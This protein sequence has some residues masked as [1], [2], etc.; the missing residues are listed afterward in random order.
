MRPRRLRARPT[1]WLGAV[2]ALGWPLGPAAAQ[3]SEPLSAQ[4][5]AA[6]S[7]SVRGEAR[8]RYEGYTG[9][10]W[11]EAPDDGYLWL[12][13]MPLAKFESEAAQVVIQPILGYAVGV[14]GGPGP[15][16]RT[17]IDLLQGYA[18]FSHALDRDTRIA[19]RAGRML[20]ALGSQRLVSTRY[21]PNIPQP[22][23]GVTLHATR[24]AARVDLV[25]A[26]AV[27]IGPGNF[28]DRAGGERRLRSVYF[29][30]E[31][32]QEIGFDLYWIGFHDPAAR[33]VEG[34][35]AEARDTFGLRLFGARGRVSWNWE[36]M[37]QRGHL[38][39]RSIR[40]WSQA[41]ET[42]VAFPDAALAPQLRLRANIA[43]GDRAGTGERLESFN[44]LFPRGRYF[45]EL[46][47]LGPRNIINVNPGIVLSPA[48]G[49]Q[50]EINFAAFWRESR[51]DGI[52]DLAGRALRRGGTSGARH[53]GN[54]IEASLAYEL[55]SGVSLGASL[56]TFTAGRF[57][58]D[59]G[60]GDT[61]LMLAAEATWRF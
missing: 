36:T 51:V 15:V 18:E 47:P 21:G 33:L 24:G 55:G 35:G 26:R 7:A 54:L 52:Y 40:A 60:R 42:L 53:I 43:S 3:I 48:P 27:A 8:V 49:M 22:F 50:A 56:G 31:A 20:L 34:F 61:I 4:P 58:R 28:D 44:A 5:R 25:D 9:T 1:G 17:G 11:G 41:T 46:T 10:E 38:A 2:L 23:D 29:T 45:G 13:L 19:A 37:L 12:R 32:A 39:G 16:D 57:L 59:T 30:A 14:A 6:P